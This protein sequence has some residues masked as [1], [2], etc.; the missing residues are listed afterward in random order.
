MLVFYESSNLIYEV[1]T[2]TMPDRKSA[3]FLDL[4]VLLFS[5][6]TEYLNVDVGR[7]NKAVPPTAK[8]LY[9]MYTTE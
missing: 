4:E 7:L 8:T 1:K 2:S 5:S 3:K 6:R 9:A